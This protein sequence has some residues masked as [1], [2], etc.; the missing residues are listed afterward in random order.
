MT[1][2]TATQIAKLTAMLTGGGYKRSA[3]KSAAAKRFI[4]IG[5]QKG[6]ADPASLLNETFEDAGEII[7]RSLGSI[8]VGKAIKD[9]ADAKKAAEA[10]RANAS[11]AASKAAPAKPAKAAKAAPAADKGPTKRAVML[12]MVCS[13][14]GATEAE[15]CEAIGWKACLVT[16][17][18]AAAAEGVTLRAEKVKGGRARYF[19]QKAAA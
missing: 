18:R 16:L 10:I 19:G 11:K 5:K 17:R 14:R 15:L 3:N 7:H 1:N 13:K 6:L 4:Q 9:D 12:A 8:A 2:L